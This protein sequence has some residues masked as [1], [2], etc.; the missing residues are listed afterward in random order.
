MGPGPPDQTL[1]C[2]L[3]A[4]P[5]GRTAS[6]RGARGPGQGGRAGSGGAPGSHPAPAHLPAQGLAVCPGRVA[7]APRGWEGTAGQQDRV[8][9]PP[10]LPVHSE[11]PQK[12]LLAP[13]GT[14][15]REKYQVSGLSFVPKRNGRP[16]FRGQEETAGSVRVPAEP[17]LQASPLSLTPQWEDAT[18]GGG[19][20]GSGGPAPAQSMLPGRPRGHGKAGRGGTLP[21]R[22]PGA[23]GRVRQSSRA[24]GLKGHCPAGLLAPWS[25]PEAL[26]GPGIEALCCRLSLRAVNA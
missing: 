8:A 14:P 26:T 21:R 3:L 11:A 15:A 18:G 24:Q 20:G 10:A 12:G 6:P 9:C 5:G 22:G 19:V 7:G 13:L 2:R 1:L 25:W 17:V 23:H 4:V 16:A